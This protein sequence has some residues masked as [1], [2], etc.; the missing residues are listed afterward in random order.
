[1]PKGFQP[2]T[3][4]GGHSSTCKMCVCPLG[5]T[6]FFFGLV[7]V[8][9]LRSRCLF[10]WGHCSMGSC[11]D[12]TTRE[13]NECTLRFHWLPTTANPKPPSPEW[14]TPPCLL[15]FQVPGFQ[16]ILATLGVR[17]KFRLLPASTQETNHPEKK[18]GA[19]TAGF[20]VQSEERGHGRGQR[21]WQDHLAGCHGPGRWGD[22]G[23]E[24][25][26]DPR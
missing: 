11:D 9:V 13:V 20:P 10:C 7:G 22:K 21:L 1:M 6:Q 24:S 5:D 14:G 15:T 18:G 12:P 16:H 19:P 26:L 23:D 25:E 17:N 2:H 3:A 4:R 8:F